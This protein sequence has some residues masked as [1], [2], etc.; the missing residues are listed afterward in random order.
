MLHTSRRH[1]K[2]N[3]GG[4][5][6]GGR[7]TARVSDKQS[8]PQNISFNWTLEYRKLHHDAWIRQKPLSAAP[9]PFSHPPNIKRVL[10]VAIKTSSAPFKNYAMCCS[11]NKRKQH[12]GRRGASVG[13]V[14][15]GG[16]AEAAERREIIQ[17]MKTPHI[18]LTIARVADLFGNKSNS[19]NK[20][21]KTY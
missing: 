5:G 9:F 21:K 16:R 15:L 13:E 17:Y 8:E 10:R 7:T 2:M 20:R 12:R 18:K 19:N 3:R 11:G 4:A 6:K 1:K 14:E